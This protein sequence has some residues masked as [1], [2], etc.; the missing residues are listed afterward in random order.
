MLK[1]FSTDIVKG[2]AAAAGAEHG[3][4]PQERLDR[5]DSTKHPRKNGGW[6]NTLPFVLSCLMVGIESRSF[7]ITFHSSF[8]QVRLP[9]TMKSAG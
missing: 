4:S 5:A 6:N 7:F 2:V 8:L 9:D 1:R 3:R